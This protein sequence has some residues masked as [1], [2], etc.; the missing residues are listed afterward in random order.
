[1]LLLP[2]L[3]VQTSPPNVG[4]HSPNCPFP[5]Q[6]NGCIVNGPGIYRGT[7]SIMYCFFGQGTLYLNNTFYAWTSIR[8]SIGHASPQPFCPLADGINI[9]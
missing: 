4:L 8:A 1:L 9:L 3:P 7:A 5:F 6:G 2:F